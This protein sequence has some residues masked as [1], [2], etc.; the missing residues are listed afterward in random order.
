MLQSL[1]RDRIVWTYNA[2]VVAQNQHNTTTA[3]NSHSSSIS[4]SPQRSDSPASPTSVSSSVMSSNSGSKGGNGGA[5][6]G[7]SS[8]YSGMNHLPN[9]TG[10]LIC[11]LNGDQSVSEAISNISSPDYQDDD[12]LLSSKDL[13]A[14]ALSDPSDS[15]STILVSEAADRKHKTGYVGYFYY[16]YLK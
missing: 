12:N 16:F 8:N 13:A 1:N 15:D 10:F 11:P 6:G 14:M 2:P 7:V 9:Q 5:V 4:S 3:S